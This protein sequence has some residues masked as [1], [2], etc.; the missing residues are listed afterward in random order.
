MSN[1]PPERSKDRDAISKLSIM[2]L[3]DQN[4]HIN[5]ILI[6]QLGSAL[7]TSDA[8][9]SGAFELL[10]S[11]ATYALVLPSEDHVSI[12]QWKC[13]LKFFVSFFLFPG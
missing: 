1:N 2:F 13:V 7:I 11:R 10:K 5:P 6:D 4:H 3:I 9:D 12:H 8:Y